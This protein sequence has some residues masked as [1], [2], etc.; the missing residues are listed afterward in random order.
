V[1]ERTRA[2]NRLHA[3]L[4]DLVPGGA[5]RTLPADRAARV[6]RGIRPKGG[7]SFVSALVQIL[8]AIVVPS[9]LRRRILRGLGPFLGP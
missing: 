9:R 3:F 6:L 2:L 7:A 4:R 8:L 5:P 1:A